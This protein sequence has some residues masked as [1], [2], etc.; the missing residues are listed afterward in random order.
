MTATGA[1]VVGDV[2]AR[3]V[4]LRNPRTLMMGLVSRL[5]NGAMMAIP[6][7]QGM[8]AV[9]AIA[10]AYHLAAEESHASN[11]PIDEDLCP[12]CGRPIHPARNFANGQP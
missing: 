3:C 6:I 11:N 10:K 12:H 7:E 8:D 2:W 4:P 5:G 1:I 9:Q